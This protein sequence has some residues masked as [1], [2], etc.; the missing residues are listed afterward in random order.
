[1]IGMV[2]VLVIGLAVAAPAV[3]TTSTWSLN[4]IGQKF[5]VPQNGTKSYLLVQVSGTWTSTIT[6]GVRNLPPG[7]S[8]TVGTIPPG[9]NDT[10]TI[11]G[12]I[13]V[14]YAAAPVG[15]YHAEVWATDGDTTQTTPVLLRYGTGSA[16][17]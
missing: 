12:F 2:A 14:T 11:N 1:M 10:S 5:C 9:S 7:S 15:D 6:Y 13:G 8:G 17:W 16:C 4:D 3:A